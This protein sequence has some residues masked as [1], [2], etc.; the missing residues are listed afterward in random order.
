MARK[1]KKKLFSFLSTFLNDPTFV[2]MGL[3]HPRI[4]NETYGRDSRVYVICEDVAQ[5]ESLERALER[6]GGFSI[7][8]DYMPAGYG[9]PKG[10]VVE[11]GV[12][13][14]KGW[15]HDE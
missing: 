11:V 13:Y 1:S 9:R 4:N 15:H 10:K 7:G 3:K 14:F 5:R 8:Y 6:E 2:S 12:S